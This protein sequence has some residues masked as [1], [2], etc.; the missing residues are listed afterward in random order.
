MSLYDYRMSADL[1]RSDPT[2]GA[3]IMAALRKADASSTGSAVALLLAVCG[4]LGFAV[5][6][7]S[8]RGAA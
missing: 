8:L 1:V 5:A 4:G 3:L 7:L 2:F 6:Y